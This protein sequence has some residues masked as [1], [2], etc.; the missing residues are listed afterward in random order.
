MSKELARP[1]LFFAH[2]ARLQTLL[3]FSGRH[4]E[5]IVKCASPPSRAFTARAEL[6]ERLYGKPAAAIGYGR[7]IG[8]ALYAN[9]GLKSDSMQRLF[10]TAR[11]CRNVVTS[12]TAATAAAS[13]VGAS[14]TATK[15]SSKRV[16][17][18]RPVG[19]WLIGSSFLVFGIVVIGGLTRLTESGLS[20]TEWKPVTGS[21]PPLTQKDWEEEFEKYRQSPEFKLLNSNMTLEEFKFIFFMEWSHRL[22][23]R[24]IGLAFVI[25]GAYFIARGRV[26]VRVT[27]RIAAIAGLIGFQGF[28]GWWMVKSGLS[29]H[30]L[31]DDGV[32]GKY[33]DT[34]PRV[35]QYRL[36]THLGLAFIVY[37]SMLWTGLEVLKE[38]RLVKEPNQSLALFSQLRNPALKKY[39]IIA[40]GL[41]ALVF[42]TAMSGKSALVI[43]F[44]TEQAQV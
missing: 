24:I 26:S 20:I 40:A 7:G 32:N 6:H 23:G 3:K 43:L 28:I 10:S 36:A 2:N 37:L 17:S 34:H 19:L 29:D 21:I 4:I 25:P 13:S 15:S 38:N 14:A 41:L 1:A 31:A 16:L 22:W 11:V 5:P 44:M 42:T 9:T 30:F 18:A 33:K 39:K 8:S 35:S 12:S 27:K